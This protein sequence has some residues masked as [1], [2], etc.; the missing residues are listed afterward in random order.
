MTFLM[1]VYGISRLYWGVSL[2]RM[3]TWP[4]NHMTHINWRSAVLVGLVGFALGPSV[5]CG[6]QA[7]R[8]DAPES[9]VP[10][11]AV[12]TQEVALAVEGMT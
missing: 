8:V 7:D 9:V 12:T 11:L 5:S 10:A 1:R 4:G 2:R 6:G 3:V